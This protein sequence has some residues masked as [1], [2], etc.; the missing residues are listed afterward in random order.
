V[1]PSPNQVTR[2]RR[3]VL[4]SAASLIHLS[5][6]WAA[7]ATGFMQLGLAGMLLLTLVVLMTCSLFLLVTRFGLNLRFSDPS[8]TLPQ[9]AWAIVLVFVSAHFAG[10][11]RPM[12]LM[13][14]LLVLMFGAFRL[15]LQ[16][17][18]RIGL[19][20]SICYLALVYG[21]LRAG[22]RLDLRLELM[23]GLAFILLCV[24]VVLLG[25]DSSRLRSQLQERNRDLRMALERIQ[26]LAITDELTGL[27]NRRFAKELMGQQKALAD[28]GNHSFVLCLLDIDFFKQVNDNFGHA[29]GDAVLQ[30]LADELHNAVRDVDFV[31]RFGG[32]EF[33]LL[34]S[35]T[36]EEGAQHVLERLRQSLRRCQWPGCPGLA[37]TVSIGVS[38]Y[39][40]GEEWHQT[41]LRVD[42]ALYRAKHNGR[43]QVVLL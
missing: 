3:I 18:L 27:Y 40:P 24:G 32:E 42:E 16:G 20:T 5:L 13:M 19:F 12:F 11:L 2:M 6:C 8:L 25:L 10:E 36:D 29:G 17:F 15:D 1:Q 21:E 38:Q 9:M 30:Q 23:N 35:G 26:Q 34:L 37:L 31:A 41:L 14:V 4:A 43:D 22:E 33:L 7:F 39:R 28:R